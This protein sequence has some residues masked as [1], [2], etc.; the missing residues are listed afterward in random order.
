MVR[1][2]IRAE[3]DRHQTQIERQA[4]LGA[5]ERTYLGRNVALFGRRK[6]LP[7]SRT[8]AARLTKP[9]QRQPKSTVETVGIG[10][11]PDGFGK[12]V[13]WA[14]DDAA[15]ALLIYLNAGDYLGVAISGVRAT[16]TIEFV[17]STGVASYAE[18]T[19]NE[20]VASFIGIVAAGASAAA[21]AYGAPEAVPVIEAAD[22]FAQSRFKEKQVKTKRRD[23]FG[24]DPGT[25]HKARE[26][27]GVIVCLPEA[28]QL[29]YSGDSDHEERWI[30]EPGTRDD[31][32]RPDHVKNAFFLRG[33]GSTNRRV[34][35][36]D[37]AFLIAPWD[38]QFSD[39]FGFYRL[40]ALVKRGSGKPKK[41]E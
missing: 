29:F 39:N 17:E 30:K 24:E 13:L 38:F 34:A 16:D 14:P 5:S 1:A 9:G 4:R 27:G 26:E 23:P 8:L 19:E 22:K 25:G 10:Q 21:S 12:R 11:A 28:R 2:G 18:E 20:G 35:G 33:G 31:A 15:L 41:V 37:G 40:E 6:R 3:I 32:H 7:P 36:G